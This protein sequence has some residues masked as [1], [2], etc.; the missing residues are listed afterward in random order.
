M[1]VDRLGVHLQHTLPQ[2]CQEKLPRDR[3][4]H[5]YLQTTD[6]ERQKAVPIEMPNYDPGKVT[7]DILSA[8]RTFAK[9]TVTA[10]TLQGKKKIALQ[11]MCSIRGIEYSPNATKQILAEMLI[12]KV[13]AHHD[14]LQSRLF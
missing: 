2:R 9:D 13:R 6:V 5:L 4:M 11:E 7:Q 8:E 14:T 10:K 1:L 12:S 3:G